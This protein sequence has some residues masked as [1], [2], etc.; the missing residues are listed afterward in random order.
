MRPP[1]KNR[2]LNAVKHL[3]CR[4]VS[5]QEND[6]D[7]VLINQILGEDKDGGHKFPASMMSY[8]L[9]VDDYVELTAGWATT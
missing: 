9:P 5:L 2:Y 3:P 1:D 6:P 8:E 4:E 7:I